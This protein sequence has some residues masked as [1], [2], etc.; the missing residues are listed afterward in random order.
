M[1][2]HTYMYV[3]ECNAT[4]FFIQLTDDFSV[5]FMQFPS[6]SSKQYLVAFFMLLLCLLDNNNQKR[7]YAHSCTLHS[8]LLQNCRHTVWSSEKVQT[9]IIW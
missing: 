5:S 6:S 2:R 7:N 8:P 1:Y 4:G 9:R 3:S